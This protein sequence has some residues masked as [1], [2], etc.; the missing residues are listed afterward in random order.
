[1]RVVSG[2]RLAFQADTGEF[3]PLRPL[4]NLEYS[5]ISNAT[6]WHYKDIKVSG[7]KDVVKEVQIFML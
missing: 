4:Q 3:D 1:M 6:T 7:K 5:L 2:V